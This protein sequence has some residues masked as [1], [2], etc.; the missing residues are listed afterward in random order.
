MP[1]P[2]ERHEKL[3]PMGCQVSSKGRFRYCDGFGPQ[4]IVDGIGSRVMGDDG[5]WYIDWTMGLGAVTL[6]HDRTP[7][8]DP[9]AWP[10]P[11]LQELELAELVQDMM[12]SCEAMRFMKNGTDATTAAV[13]LARAYTERD[14]ILRCGYHGWSD[15]FLNWDWKDKRG[16]PDCVRDLTISVPYVDLAALDELLWTKNV[17][18]FIVEPAPLAGIDKEYLAG[19]KEL[20]SAHGTVLIF[21]EVI[22]GFRMAPGGAQEIAGVTPH[23]TTAGKAMGNGQPISVVGGER[24][25]MEHWSDTHLSGTHFGEVGAMEAAI[26]NLKK[27]RE[28]N[29]WAHQEK[30]GERLMYGYRQAFLTHRLEGRTKIKGAAHHS[31][32]EWIDPAEGTL[33]A[34]EMLRRGV[35]LASGQFVCLDH[36]E[37]DVALTVR[38]YEEAMGVVAQALSQ[39]AVAK[40]LECKVNTVLFQRHSR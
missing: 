39:G 12:P 18:A 35:L 2:R 33:F 20:C 3:I 38:A 24:K 6:G 19:A 13:R 23:L 37:E 36:S 10:L 8:N 21:D 40:R 14:R 27:M 7:L 17:A 5:K 29:F 25:I 4:F 15:V 30:I 22:S 32:I 26:F 34:Q 31:N 16:V 1:S 11:S 28:E 9:K